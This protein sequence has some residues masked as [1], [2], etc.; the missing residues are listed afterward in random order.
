MSKGGRISRDRIADA[1]IGARLRE[2]RDALGLTQPQ[3]LDVLR[4]RGSVL[5]LLVLCCLFIVPGVVYLLYMLTGTY[6]ECRKC[7]AKDVIGLDT[8]RGREL[9]ARYGGAT[10][11]SW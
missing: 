10:S 2:I 11:R 5:V 6:K 7:G 1:A 4:E 3:M 9:V 8:P